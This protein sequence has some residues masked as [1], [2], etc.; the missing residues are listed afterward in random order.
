MSTREL[1]YTTDTG[2]KLFSRGPSDA[3]VYN[4]IFYENVYLPALEALVALPYTRPRVIVDL[5]ANVGFFSFYA[6]N[7]LRHAHQR[8]SIYAVEAFPPTVEEF[9]LRLREHD[10]LRSTEIKVVSG[11][12]GKREGSE[13]FVMPKAYFDGEKMDHHCCA[14]TLSS[15]EYLKKTGWRLDEGDVY[16]DIPYVDLE[17]FLPTGQID[18]LKV[19]IEGS[20]ELFL[21]NY[22]GLLRR[23][24]ILAIEMHPPCNDVE[25]CHRY[26][27]EYGFGRK[28]VSK[29]QALE[30]YVR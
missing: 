22:P 11:L 3:Q 27:E 1:I 15:M 23:T 26:L 30:F 28:K 8:H 20:E 6:I 19:D 5:G 13:A 24:K 16:Q 29:E 9:V 2:I 14:A 25:Q 4:E 12:V 21:K 10:N 17:K 18:L 7:C